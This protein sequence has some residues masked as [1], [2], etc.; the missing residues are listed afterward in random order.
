MTLPSDGDTS[1]GTTLNAHINAEHNADGSHNIVDATG[2]YVTS[3]VNGTDTKVYTK[4]LT[5]TLDADANTNVAHGVTN[6]DPKILSVSAAAYQDSDGVVQ[7]RSQTSAHEFNLSWDDTNIRFTSVGA[8]L[9]GNAYYIKI[10]Y[11]L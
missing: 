7:V 10:D 4:Y 8:N 6:G 5:G 11:I 1:W 2:P 9:Q 3:D